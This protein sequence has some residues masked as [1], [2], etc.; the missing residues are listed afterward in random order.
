[1]ALGGMDG[2]GEIQRRGREVEK[3]FETKPSRSEEELERQVGE[4][5]RSKK[6]GWFRR[7]KKT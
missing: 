6:R 2:A 3:E 4:K 7:R 1:M 5:R